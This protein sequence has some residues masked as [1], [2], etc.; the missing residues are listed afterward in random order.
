MTKLENRFVFEPAEIL[1]NEKLLDPINYE[2]ANK[3]LNR[4]I[5]KTRK[6]LLDALA[7]P[8][9]IRFVEIVAILKRTIIARI[10]KK[11]TSYFYLKIKEINKP[12]S[13][14]PEQQD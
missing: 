10:L 1:E 13:Q 2:Y 8:K 12:K 9:K 6:W 11:L 7:A 3:V 5:E 4:E 14:K